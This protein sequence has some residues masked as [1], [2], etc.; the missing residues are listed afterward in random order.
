MGYD[1]SRLW[2]DILDGEQGILQEFKGYLEDE[3]ILKARSRQRGLLLPSRFSGRWHAQVWHNYSFDKHMFENVGINPAGFGGD[4]MH[5]AR[6]LDSS[7]K[8]GKGYS[9]ES[10]TTDDTMMRSTD[11][12]DWDDGD[13]VQRGKVSM[14]ELFGKANVRKDGTDGKLVCVYFS[15]LLL[16][17]RLDTRSPYLA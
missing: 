9:L 17:L 11:D 5:M 6:L 12:E 16:V 7:R 14:K 1:K 13:S 15:R 10:L 3:R 4:T 2:V 8:A